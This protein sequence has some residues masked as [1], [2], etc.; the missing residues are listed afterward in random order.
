MQPTTFGQWV[1]KLRAEQDLT[2]EECSELV[3]C[4]T[5]TLR[6]FEIGLRR[7]SR[8]MAERIADV[9]KV[10]VTQRSEFT[11][12]AR[13]P[14]EVS[15]PEPAEAEPI[16]LHPTASPLPSLPQPSYPMIGRE[17]ERN[18]LHALL[19]DERIRLVTI[20]GAGG[21]G[22]TRLALDLAANVHDAFADGMAFVA[23]AAV[24]DVRNLPFMLA[25]TL[26]ISLQG[27]L[28][29]R[30]HLLAQ[31]GDRQLLLVLDNFEHLL[32]EAASIVWIRE[33]QQ[34]A[35]RVQLLVT[36]RERL[37]ISGER[38]FELGGLALPISAQSSDS[39]DA[40]MLF[41]DR[42]Q[43]AD[44]HFALD[45]SNRNDIVRICQLL[46][47]M[48][49]GIELAAA[50]VRILS[51]E[52]IAVEI[53]RNIDFLELADRD[54]SPRHR[55][56]RAVFDHSWHLLNGAEQ[57]SLMGLSYFRGGCTRQAAEQVAGVTLPLLASLIDKSLIVRG[58]SGRFALHE[59][60]RQFAAEHLQQDAARLAQIS[61]NHTRYFCNFL[62]RNRPHLE[63]AQQYATM[64]DIATEIE[65]L[66]LAWEWIC[67][68]QAIELVEPF[69]LSLGYVLDNRGHHQQLRQLMDQGV[70][71]F[72]WVTVPSNPTPDDRQIGILALL[73]GARGYA[74]ARLYR[75]MDAL[76]D[77]QQ[78]LL[79]ARQSE[80]ST[81]LFYTTLWSGFTFST[82][83]DFAQGIPLLQ[84]ALAH[85]QERQQS[86]EEALS[87][88]LLGLAYNL[89]GDI[90]NGYPT[91]LSAY[92][93]LRKLGD[94][95]A[96]AICASQLSSLIEATGLGSE[97]FDTINESLRVSSERGDLWAR[98]M[99]LTN[100]GVF[101]QQRG[102]LASASSQLQESIQLL[103]E[104]NEQWGTTFTQV[105]LAHVW[106][107]QGRTEEAE[108][109]LRS[110]VQKANTAQMLH[111]RIDAEINLVQLWQR[112]AKNEAAQRLLATLHAQ[113]NLTPTQRQRVQ[114]LSSL[115]APSFESHEFQL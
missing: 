67:A 81:A 74:V 18:A 26:G 69:I 46:G 43:H 103:G 102:D 1:K 73:T 72:S 111:T 110:V 52:E 19:V 51:C 84:E 108:Q 109:M 112:Q 75:P 23:L 91:T 65:N 97:L 35:P 115:S 98:A 44:S 59:L 3:G 71:A 29:V 9:L 105:R 32:A 62:R 40:L 49:L 7:P 70:R 68:H 8:E 114:E 34:S 48:P 39:S 100:M 89:S 58:E 79:L 25:E 30:Q 22:K 64:S 16:N 38:T 28:D 94:P 33:L 61:Q 53:A 41:L 21:M 95:H 24:Q 78:G 93:Q 60:I 45:A 101:A 96:L 27:V 20:V 12:L 82:M 10:P 104:V 56:I 4:A 88:M 85:S 17:A 31:L 14:L 55:N 54:A 86:W 113:P 6:A 107:E 13:Q 106:F 80:E 77:L 5:A 2:Q 90:T 87:E 42:A 66:M 11:R 47:G 83:G 99:W 92:Q 15:Q 36:S 37:R 57:Q 63:S 76:T 50:W